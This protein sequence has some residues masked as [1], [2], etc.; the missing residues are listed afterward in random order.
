MEQDWG[1]GKVV[2]FDNFFSSV[3][4]LEKL[5]TEN[6]CACGTIRSNRKGLAGNMLVDS[7]MKR[8]DSDHRFNLD[9]STQI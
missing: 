8:G 3:A 6:T 1:K 2:Y 7:Q 4:L 5:K 9:I